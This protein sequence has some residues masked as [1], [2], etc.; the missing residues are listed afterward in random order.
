MGL[1]SVLIFFK[2]A[3][4]FLF[5]YSANAL[6]KNHFSLERFFFSSNITRQHV[7]I[8]NILQIL[9]NT[10]TLA[11]MSLLICFVKKMVFVLL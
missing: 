2:T 5:F 10:H 11:E 9:F 8:R 6:P 1:E 4:D 3:T 7:S